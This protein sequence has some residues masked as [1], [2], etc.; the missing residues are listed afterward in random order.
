[1][2]INIENETN[3]IFEFDYEKIIKE[4][5]EGAVEYVD[6]PYYSIVDVTLVDDESIREINN[7]HRNIDKATDVLSFPMI[8]YNAAGDFSHLEDDEYMDC[9]EPDSGELLLGDII[10]SIERMIAQAENYG[11]SVERELAFLVAHS[12]FHLFGYDHMEDDE[13]IQMERMQEELLNNLGITREK[14]F[15]CEIKLAKE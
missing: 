5:I 7:E 14:G 1:M 8:E 12:M 2:S 4:V 3:Y 10:I 6:C 15:V 11:H 13:R 9:F